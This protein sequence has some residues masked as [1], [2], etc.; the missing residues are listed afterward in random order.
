VLSNPFR[1]G[2]ESSGDR[3]WDIIPKLERNQRMLNIYAGNLAY[4]VTE[5]DL[6]PGIF[7]LWNGRTAPQ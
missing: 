3:G 1:L 7:G 6:P 2:D 5:E 4:T